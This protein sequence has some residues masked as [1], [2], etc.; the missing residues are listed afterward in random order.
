[1]KQA[2]V[3]ALVATLGWRNANAE[4]C[5]LIIYATCEDLLFLFACSA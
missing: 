5:Y 2:A 4:V 3:G 1:M